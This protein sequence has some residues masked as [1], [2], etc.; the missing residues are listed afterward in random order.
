[1]AAERTTSLLRYAVCPR[2]F[3]RPCISLHAASNDFIGKITIL[4]MINQEGEA[5]GLGSHAARSINCYHIPCMKANRL[6]A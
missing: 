4:S 1:M 3:L 5:K 6:K 2:D